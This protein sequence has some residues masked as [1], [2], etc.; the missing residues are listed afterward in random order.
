MEMLGIRYEGLSSHLNRKLKVL[1]DTED[2][3]W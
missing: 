1:T 2:R 3:D